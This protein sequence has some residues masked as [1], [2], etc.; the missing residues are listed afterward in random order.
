MPVRLL[1]GNTTATAATCGCSSQHCNPNSPQLKVNLVFQSKVDVLMHSCLQDLL[2]STHS[3][4]VCCSNLVPNFWSVP[5]RM[6]Q[7]LYPSRM[8]YRISLHESSSFK[9]RRFFISV[10]PIGNKRITLRVGGNFEPELRH[11]QNQLDALQLLPMAQSAHLTHGQHV[12]L[13]RDV[14]PRHNTTF[15]TGHPTL[16]HCLGQ[17]QC[18]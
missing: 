3:L 18:H 7:R 4:S 17:E 9:R 13:C 8:K 6:P 10:L 5:E 16:L 1:D 15:L 2:A 11:A 12:L 14:K